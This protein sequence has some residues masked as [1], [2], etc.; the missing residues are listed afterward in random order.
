MISSKQIR[1]GGK[2]R[3]LNGHVAQQTFSST[4][5]ISNS[6]GHTRLVFHHKSKALQ[7]GHPRS[8]S[9][10]DLVLLM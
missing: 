5:G 9:G 3:Y 4:Q 10:R 1:E 8:M 6:V 7:I 2:P